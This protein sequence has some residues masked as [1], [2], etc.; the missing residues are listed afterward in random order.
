MSNPYLLLTP[1]PLSTTST[2]KEAMLKDWCTWDHDYKTIVQQI[3]LQLL[4]VGRASKEHYT[5]LFMQGSGTFGIEST[6]GSVIPN[7]GKLLILRNGAYGKRIEEIAKVLQISYVSLIFDTNTQV[8]PQAVER[9]LV[10]DT[11]ITHVAMVHCETTTGIL[12]PLE[13]VIDVIKRNNRIAIIDAMSSFGGIPI[14]VEQLQIDFIISSANKCIQG[15]PGFSFIL[16][17][18]NELKKCKGRAR[19]L[20][21]DLYDQ[22]DTMEQDE[23]KWRFTSPTHVVYA[24]AQALKELAE[25]G[26][27]EA[28]HARYC[29]N[30]QMVVEGLVQAGFTTYLARE[31]HSPII[32]TFLYPVHFPFSFD[33]FYHDLKSAGYVI[34]PG[35]LTDANVFRIGNIGDVHA[36]DMKKLSEQILRYVGEMKDEN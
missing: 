26:G 6:I 15:V 12:N 30:Q 4:E 32:T 22:W 29:R 17:Q 31:F 13:A 8:D 20:S 3:R 34:Y 36:E 5:A 2:V 23:G 14:E 11:S 21:L 25:E 16:C 1:G 9:T 33:H 28:R 35:K 24:F 7:D 10:E 19:S 18:R 27:V